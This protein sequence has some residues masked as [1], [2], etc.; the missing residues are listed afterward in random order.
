M[1]AG[2]VEEAVT[3]F[4]RAIELSKDRLGR[5]FNEFPRGCCGDASELLAAYLKDCGLGEFSYVSGW[6]AQG[7]LSHAWLE[8]DGLV[9]DITADQFEGEYRATIVELYSD[10]H[11]KF[12][13]GRE[14]KHNADFRAT[15][16]PPA[17]LR[18]AYSLLKK[19]VEIELAIRT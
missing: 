16:N 13:R 17:H 14:M 3:R 12:S 5:H 11:K 9:I 19:V 4:R 10:W 7:E 8:L 18:R 6:D 2:L 1:N 15:D